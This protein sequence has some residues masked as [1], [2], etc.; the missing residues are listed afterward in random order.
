M[1]SAG[2]GWAPR[3]ASPRASLALQLGLDG[4]VPL[5]RPEFTLDDAVEVL[6]VGPFAI[7]AW[8]GV[9]GRFSL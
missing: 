2:V 9:L 3:L 7:R 6:T 4:V 5:L 8:L 1:A